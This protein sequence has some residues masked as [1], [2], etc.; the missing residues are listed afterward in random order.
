M[1]TIQHTGLVEIIRQYPP[2]AVEVLR[3]TGT[4]TIPAGADAALG[5]DGTSVVVSDP[6][7][8]ER[9]LAIVI[10]S[11]DDD[12]DC[13]LSVTAARGANGCPRAVLITACWEENEAARRRRIVAIGHP[14]FV[15]VP[16][17]VDRKTPFNLAAGSPYLTLFA[18]VLGGVAMETESG[19]RQVAQAILL[20]GAGQAARRAL[21]DAI[22]G[23]ASDAARARLE[24]L[25]FGATAF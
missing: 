7:T 18:A 4:F 10:A 8:G 3:H 23:I 24:K 9:L 19:S 15:F 21:T 6:A 20:T 13:P 25:M 1:P 17:V 2:V 16:I 22:W 5:P 14:G 12:G 11:Q